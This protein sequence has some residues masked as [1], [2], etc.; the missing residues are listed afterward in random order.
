M[1][2]RH[3]FGSVMPVGCLCCFAWCWDGQDHSAAPHRHGR[4]FQACGDLLFFPI[5]HCGSNKGN[6]KGQIF[7]WQKL[8][9]LFWVQQSFASLQRLETW[10]LSTG[11]F[12]AI[13]HLTLFIWAEYATRA[14]YIVVLYISNTLAISLLFFKNKTEKINGKRKSILPCKSNT[15]CI[16]T[17]LMFPGES[18]GQ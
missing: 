5:N 3:F 17:I 2:K 13:R 18:K 14:K 12:I 1:A 16:T 15:L 8:L 9:W 11:F 10:S 4:A 7:S 6:S